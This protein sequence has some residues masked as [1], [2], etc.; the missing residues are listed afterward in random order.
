VTYPHVSPCVIVLIHDGEHILLTHKP[1]WGP[2]HSIVAGFVEPGES[3]EECLV[4]EVRE[5]VGAEVDEVRYFHS[6]PWPFPHQLMIGFFARYIGGEI[7]PDPSELD[8]ARWFHVDELP[9]I[10]PPLSIARRMIDAWV[11]SLRG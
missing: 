10:P 6:Q 1:G 4:R 9:A 8:V 5:E 11:A 3:L 7:R 2:M